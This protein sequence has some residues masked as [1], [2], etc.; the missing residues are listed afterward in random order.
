MTFFGKSN[1]G[2]RRNNNEDSFIVKPE[3]NF[4][5][6]AD[7]MGGA[8]SGELASS[9]FVETVAEVFSKKENHSEQVT[10]DLILSS[11]KLANERILNRAKENSKH[12]GMG[13]TAELLAFYNQNMVVGHVG[14]SR[15]YILREGSLRKLT[16]DHSLVQDQVNQ[17]LITPSDAKRHSLRH[18][19]LRAVGIK[20]DLEVDIIR[21]NVMPG[22]IFLLC[23]D[24]LT[25]MVDDSTIQEILSISLDIH[26]K[27]DNLI[28]AANSLG[29]HD[30][31]TVILCETPLTK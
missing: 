4:C 21:G 13:C 8:A 20:D 14:D 12:E 22:D 19:I 15:T 31:I 9:I 6:L 7:G 16:E 29:G 30:N 28:N 18:V 24:G 26:K 25:D 3:Q 1:T 5:A 11:F 27:A 10:I 2:L 23:S 17:G